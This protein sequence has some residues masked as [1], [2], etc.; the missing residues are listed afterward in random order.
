M[1][2]EELKAKLPE[3][4]KDVAMTKQPAPAPGQVWLTLDRREPR[5][6]RVV[7]VNRDRGRQVQIEHQDTNRRTNASLERFSGK[8]GGYGFLLALQ[9]AA[10]AP[11]PA[12]AQAPAPSFELFERDQLQPPATETASASQVRNLFARVAVLEARERKRS[13]VLRQIQRHIGMALGE[14]VA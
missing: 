8:L 7:S 10:P 13:Q 2:N 6:V 14:V 11:A 12:P 1:N 5:L 9:P 4:I 3:Y